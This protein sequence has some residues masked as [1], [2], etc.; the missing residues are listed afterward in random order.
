MFS[1]RLDACCV[2]WKVVEVYKNK[3]SLPACWSYLYVHVSSCFVRCSAVPHIWLFLTRVLTLNLRPSY[4]NHL[5]I[6]RFKLTF[7]Y[8]KLIISTYHF[9]AILHV[10]SV[11]LR[12]WVTL[13]KGE[14][15]SITANFSSLSP[16]KV[17]SFCDFIPLTSGNSALH[18]A[19]N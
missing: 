12:C 8:F 13:F 6:Y 10:C 2:L 17:D 7:Y 4:L 15:Y 19:R 9:L 11:I 18:L 5:F 14:N 3:L 1:L 16:L